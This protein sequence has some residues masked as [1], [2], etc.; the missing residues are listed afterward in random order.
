MV[1]ILLIEQVHLVVKNLDTHQHRPLVLGTPAEGLHL[2]RLRI[3][4]VDVFVVITLSF[5]DLVKEK[6]QQDQV[7]VEILQ[8]V[9][10][11]LRKVCSF[12]V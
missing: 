10:V 1:S 2:A 12:R 4:L 11:N 9:L 5:V 8:Q 6:G 7:V 3:L